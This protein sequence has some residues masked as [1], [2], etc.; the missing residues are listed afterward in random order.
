M[1]H[2]TPRLPGVLATGRSANCH[3]H[4]YL[5][6]CVACRV[7]PFVLPLVLRPHLPV[8]EFKQQ[9]QLHELLATVSNAV[10]VAA[11][12]SAVVVMIPVQRLAVV[13]VNV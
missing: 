11:A 5:D 4:L 9:P 10:G 6:A 7:F 1:L 8:A 12:G 2:W 3:T 13:V